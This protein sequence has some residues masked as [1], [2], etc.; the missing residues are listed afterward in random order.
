LPEGYYCDRHR[1]PTDEPIAAEPL[2]RRVSVTLEVLFAAVNW[3]PGPGPQLEALA[4]LETAV[5]EAGGVINLHA[6]NSVMGRCAGLAVARQADRGPGPPVVAPREAKS[7]R[8]R[9]FWRLSLEQREAKS[10]DP[11]RGADDEP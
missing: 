11:R 2:I 10:E 6:V 4:R 9:R 7:A 1:R 8:P 5:E 3:L